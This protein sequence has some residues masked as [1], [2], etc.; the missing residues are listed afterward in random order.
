M[1]G[2]WRAAVFLLG[3]WDWF[4]KDEDICLSPAGPVLQGVIFQG[5]EKTTQVLVR[6][7]GEPVAGKTWRGNWGRDPPNCIPAPLCCFAQCVPVCG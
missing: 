5:G 4:R 3:S 7:S 2:A 6:V 1:A